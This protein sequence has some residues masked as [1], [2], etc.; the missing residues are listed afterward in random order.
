MK[1]IKFLFHA[2]VSLALTASEFGGKNRRRAIP[3]L[4]FP[5]KERAGKKGAN[6]GSKFFSMFGSHWRKGG[7]AFIWSDIT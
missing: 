2:A 4:I 5:P 3:S 7:E 1:R 6:I